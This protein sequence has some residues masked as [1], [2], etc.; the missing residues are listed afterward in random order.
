MRVVDEAGGAEITANDLLRLGGNDVI[1][2][3]LPLF[4][5]FGQTCTLNTAVAAG[6]T[7]TLLPRFDPA[8]ALRILADHRAT[9]FA[10]VPTMYGAMLQVPERA[11]YDL[12]A[13]RVCMT[14]GAAMPVEVLRQFEDTF[15][16]IVLEGYGLSETTPVA[17][18]NHWNATAP[19][20]WGH[21]AK[22][23]PR[24]CIGWRH[25]FGAASRRSG[26]PTLAPPPGVPRLH[27]NH[28]QSDTGH[29]YVEEGDLPHVA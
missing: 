21:L 12:S 7:L 5:S 22:D 4:H 2:G 15:G 6:A 8:Q 3:G 18:F 19:S 26:S 10:G 28:D 27:L 24:S 14:G 13:L 29:R 9:V 17:S 16:C 1:F 23:G 11:D 25:G 20:R